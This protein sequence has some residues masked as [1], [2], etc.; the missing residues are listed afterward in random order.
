MVHER[1]YEKN[2]YFELIFITEHI[3]LVLPIKH[4]VNQDVE[5]T[6]P[7]KLATGTKPSVSNLHVLFRPCV[8]QKSTEYVD[9]KAL[10][11][12]HG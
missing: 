6:M 8:V 2:I 3:L 12:R 10:N 1:V 9:T 7:H 4:L 5:P 11:M